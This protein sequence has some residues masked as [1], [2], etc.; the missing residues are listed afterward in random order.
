MTL[1]WTNALFL[2]KTKGLLEEDDDDDFLS[3]APEAPLAKS[4][5]KTT[6]S[7]F[8]DDEGDEDEETNGGLPPPVAT[9][10]AV[11]NT[12][13]VCVAPFPMTHVAWV[14][15]NDMCSNGFICMDWPF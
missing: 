14:Y 11:K 15:V 12:L 5:K 13:K 10:P 1:L 3:E 2:Q 9:K 4:A 7:L 6:V 8:D